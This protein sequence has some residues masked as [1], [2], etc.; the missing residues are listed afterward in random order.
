[1]HSFNGNLISF[2]FYPWNELIQCDIQKAIQF[3]TWMLIFNVTVSSLF[4]SPTDCKDVTEN[5]NR[6]KFQVT[7]G[8]YGQGKGF[9]L[10]SFQ[11][12][13]FTSRN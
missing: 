1:M 13:T 11:F 10:K 6:Q 12:S 8:G 4:G 7:I 3:K 5:W 2:S 9:K